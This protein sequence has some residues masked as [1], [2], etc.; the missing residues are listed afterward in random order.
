MVP[1]TR[2]SAA[3][4]SSRPLGWSRGG[5]RGE[6]LSVGHTVAY[7]S[8]EPRGIC[9]EVA[10][11][12]TAVLLL[13]TAPQTPHPWPPSTAPLLHLRIP[14]ASLTNRNTA[15][16]PRLTGDLYLV[17]RWRFGVEVGRMRWQQR[18]RSGSSAGSGG[19]ANAPRCP[20]RSRSRSGHVHLCT[21]PGLISAEECGS[22]SSTFVRPLR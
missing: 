19:V 2:A 16:R 15:V 6:Q 21:Q 9:L 7:K 1:G 8:R 20:R 11:R 22:A 5:S 18:K 4:R 3:R 12:S 13:T 17:K 10:V 14:R